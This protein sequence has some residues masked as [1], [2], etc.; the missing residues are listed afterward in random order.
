MND[1]EKDKEKKFKLQKQK[2][3]IKAENL[4]SHQKLSLKLKI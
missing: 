4:L 2:E 3:N 1:A